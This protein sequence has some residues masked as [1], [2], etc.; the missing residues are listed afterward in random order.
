MILPDKALSP[1]FPSVGLA[2]VLCAAFCVSIF[3]QSCSSSKDSFLR[4]QLSR[5]HCFFDAEKPY[6]DEDRIA[7]ASPETWEALLEF[8]PERAAHA[9]VASRTAEDIIR[10]KSLKEAYEADSLTETRLDILELK[11][12]VGDRIQVASLEISALSAQI[13]CEEERS[14]QVATFM[15]RKESRRDKELTV[16]AIVVGAAGAVATGAILLDQGE[17]ADQNTVEIIGISVGITEA[18]L[19]TA[20]LLNKKKTEYRHPYNHL[21]CVWELDPHCE[22]IP[23]VVGYF[24][25][26]N[27]AD[28]RSYIER[29]RA[30]Y[31]GFG[32]VSEAKNEKQ[33]RE[34][35]D[36][37]FGEG[38][39]YSGEQLVERAG[40][41]DQFEAMVTLMKEDLRLLINIISKI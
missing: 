34:L 15:K 10:L 35:E 17:N 11:Q 8:L 22:L 40:M 16:G 23:P 18:A 6:E 20:L 27:G 28:Q 13:D 37:F 39:R 14:E 25:Q 29:M 19:G 4:A 41:L 3:M 36:L 31:A 26:Q 12:S 32:P 5:S 21:K 2:A 38:G 7:P 33:R 24:L 9:A 30:E 1:R